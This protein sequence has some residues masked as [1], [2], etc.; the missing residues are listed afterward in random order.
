MTECPHTQT[1]A[2]FVAG[3]LDAGRRGEMEAHVDGCRIC[4]G[5]V[6]RMMSGMTE[7]LPEGADPAGPTSPQG[8]R[9]TDPLG[10]GRKVGRYIL[11]G[12]IGA[13]GMGTVHAAYDTALDRKIALKFLSRARPDLTELAQVQAEASAMARFSHPNVVTVH[14]VGVFE[15]K[16]YLAMEFVE[17]TTLSAWR[18]EQPRSTREICRVLAGAARGLAALHAEGIIHRDVKPHNILVSGAR[19]LVTDFG[20]S[21]RAEGS[22]SGGLIA[23]TPAYMAPEQFRGEAVDAR[24]DVFGFCA[25]LF[26]MIHGVP[27]FA[28]ATPAQVKARVEAG[29]LP[30]APAGSRAPARLHRLALRGLAADQALR[31]SD[32][33][34]IAEE[35]LAD[36]TALPRRAGIGV[37]AVAA[38]V[39]AFWGGGYLKAN[40]ERRCRAGAEAMASSWNDARRAQLRGQYQAAGLAGA[41]PLLERR[42]QDYAGRWRAMHGE[43]CTAT[44][45]ERRQSEA[46]LDLRMDCLQAQRATVDALVRTLATATRAQLDKAG[47]ARLP[48]VDECEAAGRAGT[49]PLPADPRVRAEIARIESVLGQSE[50]QRF[51]GEFDRAAQSNKPALEAARKLGYEPLIARALNQAG[52][53]EMWRGAASGPTG[54][55][56]AELMGEAVAQAEVGR[57]DLRRVYAMADLVTINTF[58]DRFPEAELW[59]SLA[60]ALLTKIGNP[61]PFY[62]SHLENSVGWLKYSRG[63]REASRIAFDRA[64]ALRRGFLPPNHIMVIASLN[65]SCMVRPTLDEQNDCF[66]E[67][68]ALGESTFPPTSSDV[69]SLYNNLAIG[70]MKRPR[71]LDQA[72][73]MLRKAVAIKEASLD[74]GNPTLLDDLNNLGMCTRLQGK[75]QEARALFEKGLAQAAPKTGSHAR[76]QAGYGLTLGKL[77]QYEEGVRQLR[78]ALADRRALFGPS[79]RLT[80]DTT[81]DLA[82]VLNDQGRPA[83]ALKESDAAIAACA[84]AKTKS[85]YLIDLHNARGRALHALARHEPAIAAHQDALR[86]HGEL[87]TGTAGSSGDT[88]P[89]EVARSAALHGIGAARLGLNQNQAAIESLE[90]ALALRAP[91]EVASEL[92]AD[93]LLLLARAHRARSPRR[94]CELGAEAV[95]GYRAAGEVVS[96]ELREAQ[97]FLGDARCETS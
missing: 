44:Y 63:Q 4:D 3:K 40:P 33:N 73:P 29:R 10:E 45:G 28:E 69:A 37:A 89:S 65:G 58:R 77:G 51:M 16:A 21:V 49:K 70:L 92:R 27:P 6:A 62:R 90:Q 24:T 15:G 59:V 35:L 41:W 38:A 82:T 54:E 39:A 72:C 50:A 11:I 68:L 76:L 14:D 80:L 7:P 2:D 46:V 17:G 83:E 1:V 56:A 42:V 94:S 67:A 88:M 32:L 19:V 85:S 5:V 91:G 74:P 9:D 96:K 75:L 20:L 79:G 64:L 86:L 55:R 8:L 18:T 53:I 12:R 60:S 30:V 52:A 43:T 22:G 23:G 13:G 97:R 31:P 34:A 61:P 36:P 66:R 84:R 48:V 25:T 47:S 87:S 93:T 57:D 95:T 71:T 78:Q 26:E 81:V